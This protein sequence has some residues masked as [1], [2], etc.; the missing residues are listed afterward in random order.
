MTEHEKL[1]AG[2]DYDYT[3]PEIQALL[4][5]AR[6]LISEYNSDRELSAERKAEILSELFPE[7]GENV[8]VQKPVRAL[9]GIHTKFGDNVFVNSSC[10][11]LDGGSIT[12]GDR[13]L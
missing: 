13:V 1:A 2:L 3:D 10:V 5:R 12:I 6:A 4:S 8:T 7:H 9:Y 11:F